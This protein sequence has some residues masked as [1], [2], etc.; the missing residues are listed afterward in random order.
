MKSKIMF[1]LF[2]GLIFSISSIPLYVN[3]PL[4]YDLNLGV[5]VYE[6]GEEA[7]LFDFYIMPSLLAY[8]HGLNPK[9]VELDINIERGIPYWFLVMGDI[10]CL[11]DEPYYFQLD[12]IVETNLIIKELKDCKTMICLHPSRMEDFRELD[13]VIDIIAVDP[14]P[15]AWNRSLSYVSEILRKALKLFPNSDVWC[16]LQAWS[17]QTVRYPTE[18]ELKTMISTASQYTDTVIFWYFGLCPDSGYLG[19]YDNADF[20]NMFIGV[21]N[22]F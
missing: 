10:V 13:G 1:F 11:S 21:L 6:Y 4:L 5:Y 9:I 15:I 20:W 19:A 8:Y 16:V 2:S 12:E 3:S 14:Y 22:G 17:S 18:T 7:E